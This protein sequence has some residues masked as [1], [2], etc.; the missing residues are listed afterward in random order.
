MAVGNGR[1]EAYTAG[2]EATL[3]NPETDNAGAFAIAEAGAAP[4]AP[5]LARRDGPAGVAGTL[6]SCGMD[7]QGTWEAR[8]RPC[9]DIA[10][11][12]GPA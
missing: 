2:S 7:R 3:L 6:Q 8:F 10:G 11:G 5:Q 4:E 1:R 12:E 9:A